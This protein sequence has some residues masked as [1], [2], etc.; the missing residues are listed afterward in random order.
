VQHGVP[1]AQAAYARMTGA[2]NWNQIVSGWNTQPVWGVAP[3]A[4]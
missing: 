3:R 4:N 2:S 1:G